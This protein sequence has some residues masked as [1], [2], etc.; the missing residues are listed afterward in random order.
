MLK[1]IENTS[2]A[3]Q[4]VFENSEHQGHIPDHELIYYHH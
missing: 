4:F 2:A 1:N 3:I